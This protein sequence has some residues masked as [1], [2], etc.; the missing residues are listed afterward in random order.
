MRRAVSLK[1]ARPFMHT[2]DS[3]PYPPQ[4][5]SLG[6]FAALGHQGMIACGASA[7]LVTVH[8]PS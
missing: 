8:A 6:L 1:T 3:V 4:S 7:R 2:R 5:L